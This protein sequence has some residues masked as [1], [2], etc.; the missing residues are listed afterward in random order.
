[1]DSAE[2]SSNELTVE[3]V[4]SLLAKELNV[5][6]NA[7]ASENTVLKMT[8]VFI[9]FRFILFCLMFFLNC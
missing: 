5:K 4:G 1:M 7:I 2:L 6:P 9:I 8:E 3:A